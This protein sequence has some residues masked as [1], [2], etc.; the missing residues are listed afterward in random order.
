M[1]EQES[2]SVDAVKK[3]VGCTS[4]R[5]NDAIFE[6]RIKCRKKKRILVCMIMRL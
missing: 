2:Y 3:I 5:I 1:K 4:G 6:G